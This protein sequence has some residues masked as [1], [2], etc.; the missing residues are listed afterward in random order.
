MPPPS[1]PT[2][3]PGPPTPHGALH[4]KRV[5]ISVGG[6]R[7]ALDP[8]R[9]L[10][11]RSSGKQGMALAEAA[12][13]QGAHVTLVLAH[14]EVAPPR[15]CDVVRVESALQLRD[16]VI[17]ALPATDVLVM[18]AAVADFRPAE[19]VATKIK[20]NDDGADPVLTLVRNPDVLREAVLTRD[21][22]PA[23]TGDARP[24]VI[25]RLRRRDR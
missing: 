10:G 8:V 21:A 5:T 19:V 16:A 15:G 11:N 20:K 18:A 1:P 23:G 14:A 9:F 22:G 25:R 2:P 7:E 17:A 4:G 12:L 3:P 13:A 6:T 24:L